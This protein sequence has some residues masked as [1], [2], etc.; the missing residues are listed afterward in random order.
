MKDGVTWAISTAQ[1]QAGLAWRHG[2]AGPAPAG[3]RPEDVAAD[4]VALHATDAA[5]VHLAVAAR[6]HAPLVATVEEA[7]YERRSLLRMLGMRRTMFVV[8]VGFAPVVQAGA[9]LAVAADQRKLL[10]KHLV[11]CGVADAA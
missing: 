5:T 8:P 9:T 11:E 6:L 4:L 10:V 3:K 1:R 2:L 7:L